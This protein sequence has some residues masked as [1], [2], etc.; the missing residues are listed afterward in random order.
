MKKTAK[1]YL[2]FLAGHFTGLAISLFWNSFSEIINNYLDDYLFI[3][4]LILLFEMLE[5]FY[6]KN[7]KYLSVNNQKYSLSDRFGFKF[8]FY[9]GLGYTLFSIILRDVIFKI[10]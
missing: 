2:F 9:F 7:P 10:D 4:I 3:L 1:S 5:I 6:V 8:N